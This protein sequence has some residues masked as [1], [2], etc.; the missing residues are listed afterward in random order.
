MMTGP[1]G[2]FSCLLPCPALSHFSVWPCSG[3]GAIVSAHSQIV[4]AHSLVSGQEG[5][6]VEMV[7]CSS[8]TPRKYITI[9]MVFTHFSFMPTF[10]LQLSLARS[11]GGESSQKACCPLHASLEMLWG[12]QEAQAP[13]AASWRLRWGRALSLAC[14]PSLRA[15]PCPLCDI[16]SPRARFPRSWELWVSWRYVRVLSRFLPLFI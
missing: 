4:N 12:P 8:L 9:Y 11:S 10:A 6:H 2:F 13:L 7:I 14:P 16:F 3:A 5:F 15:L 1:W